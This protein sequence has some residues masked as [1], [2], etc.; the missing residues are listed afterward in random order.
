MMLR[1]MLMS[2]SWSLL[3]HFFV[4]DTVATETLEV[5]YRRGKG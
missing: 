5:E 2:P 4:G 3:P 1:M